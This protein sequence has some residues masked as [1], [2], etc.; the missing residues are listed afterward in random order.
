MFDRWNLIFH[1]KIGIL[2]PAVT[3][4]FDQVT[5]KFRKVLVSS[6]SCWNVHPVRNFWCQRRLRWNF[7]TRVTPSCPT[8]SLRG[9]HI[10]KFW[11]I[12]RQP[13]IKCIASIKN[14]AQQ[15]Q[16]MQVMKYRTIFIFQWG[17]INPRGVKSKFRRK[18]GVHAR[19][20]KEILGVFI[21][22]A[23]WSIGNLIA[24]RMM[25]KFHADGQ[26]PICQRP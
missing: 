13:L 21:N 3:I 4:G 2:T 9:G 22:D 10:C 7:F 14:T 8:P 20:S 16:D 19:I 12:W 1:P 15:S 18:L 5:A 26:R 25:P 24:N 23:H 17:V 11:N 6:V